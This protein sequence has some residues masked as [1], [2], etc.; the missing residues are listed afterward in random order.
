MTCTEVLPFL[1]T[2]GLWPL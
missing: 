1:G 2:L